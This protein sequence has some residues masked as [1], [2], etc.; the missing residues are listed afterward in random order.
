MGECYHPCALKLNSVV[1]FVIWPLRLTKEKVVY[2]HRFSTEGLGG[3]EELK[4]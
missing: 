3:T 1:H 4:N 2:F